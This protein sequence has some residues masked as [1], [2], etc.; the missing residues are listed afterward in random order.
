MCCFYLFIFFL[1]GKKPTERFCFE[2]IPS[3]RDWHFPI[4]KGIFNPYLQNLLIILVQC[5]IVS[6]KPKPTRRSLNVMLSS[7]WSTSTTS[8]RG[9]AEWLTSICQA[10]LKRKRTAT[11][12]AP[13]P[14]FKSRIQVIL[15]SS[16]SPTCYGAA[17]CW[18]PCWTSCRPSPCLS[19]L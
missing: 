14:E 9:F 16:A 7:F 15:P 13:F 17:V 4:F 3:L 12:T 19:V 11:H 6:Q 1:G 5:S 10:W 2:S 18:G 8:T